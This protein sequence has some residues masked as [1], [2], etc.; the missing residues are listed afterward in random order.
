MEAIGWW[1]YHVLQTVAK[2]WYA[3]A[4]ISKRIDTPGVWIASGDLG[5]SIRTLSWVAAKMM[6]KVSN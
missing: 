1:L 2:A 3:H 5:M 4:H 6:V